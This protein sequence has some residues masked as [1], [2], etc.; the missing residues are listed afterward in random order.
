MDKEQNPFVDPYVVKRMKK[1]L[2]EE[3]GLLEE[4]MKENI[5]NRTE[6]LRHFS[7]TEDKQENSN[8]D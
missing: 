3:M 7:E 8:S 1:L 5:R 2:T 6:A 4:E